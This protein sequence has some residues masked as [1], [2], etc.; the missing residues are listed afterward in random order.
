MGD[1]KTLATVFGG[2]QFAV[3]RRHLGNGC[4]GTYCLSSLAGS[5]GALDRLDRALLGSVKA[6]AGMPTPS[7]RMLQRAERGDPD[8]KRQRSKAV[9]GCL[10]DTESMERLEEVTRCTDL[11]L[12]HLLLLGWSPGASRAIRR[13]EQVA[14]RE[15]DG[16]KAAFGFPW[17]ARAVAEQDDWRPGFGEKDMFRFRVLATYAHRECVA[18]GFFQMTGE[19]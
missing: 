13:E 8:C 14:S 15:G 6:L 9:E 17:G 7:V 10:R 16:G 4:Y 2:G 19:K 11:E 3:S 18:A 5:V 12:L 1:Q